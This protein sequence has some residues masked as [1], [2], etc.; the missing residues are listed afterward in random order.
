MKPYYQESPPPISPSGN[1]PAHVVLPDHK[2]ESVLAPF[3]LLSRRSALSR[4]VIVMIVDGDGHHFVIMPLLD[5]SAFDIAI[6]SRC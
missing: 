1:P 5:L 4:V 2:D 6:A 3:F